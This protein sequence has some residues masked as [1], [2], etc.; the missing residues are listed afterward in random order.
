MTRRLV[1]LTALAALVAGGCSIV[2]TAADERQPKPCAVVYSI[3]RCAAMTDIVAA[4]V[5]KN[6]DDVAPSRSCLTRHPEA[7]TW[8]PGG[9]SASGSC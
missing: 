2:P 6:R 7:S 5:V 3:A 9:M 8:G 1:A 4:D